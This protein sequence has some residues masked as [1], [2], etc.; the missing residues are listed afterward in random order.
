MASLIW[1]YFILH[2]RWLEILYRL[3]GESR[4][5]RLESRERGSIRSNY[6]ATQELRVMLEASI[7]AG[8]TPELAGG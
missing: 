2:T 4:T 1:A 8:T 7:E 3:D 6:S 5:L